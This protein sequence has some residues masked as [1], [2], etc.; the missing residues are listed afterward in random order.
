MDH[1]EKIKKA[2]VK[3]K[4]SKCSNILPDKYVWYESHIFDRKL[5]NKCNENKMNVC[6]CQQC[7]FM[8]PF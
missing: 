6:F 3:F 2:E 1:I 4:C 8:I 5:C 7:V